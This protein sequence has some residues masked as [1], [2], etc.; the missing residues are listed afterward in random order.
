MVV[1]G[2]VIDIIKLHHFQQKF[3]INS[4]NKKY[5]ILYNNNMKDIIIK[6]RSNTIVTSR[7]GRG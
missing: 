6:K 4:N 1:E 3:T 5:P 7:V 2:W